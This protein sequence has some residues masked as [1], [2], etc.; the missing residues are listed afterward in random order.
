MVKDILEPTLIEILDTNQIPYNHNKAE[1]NFYFPRWKGL[2]WL[3]SGDKP[4]KLKGI[5]GGLIGID[6]PFIQD[7]NIY[8]IA[9]SRARHPEAKIKGLVLTGTPE[10][11]NWGY[12]LIKKDSDNVAVYRGSTHDNASNL[13]EEYIDH[14]KE[15]YSDKEI[16]AYV[17]GEFVNMTTG[18]VYYPF[19]P[20]QNVIPNY[21][22]VDFRPLEI[23]CDFNV[24]LMA[25]HIGQE[26]NGQD[27]TFDSVEL[28]GQANTELMCQML[29]SKYPNHRGGYIFFVDMAG[30]QR[31]TSATATDIQIIKE[32]FPA[33]PV[34]FNRIANIK[35]RTDALNARLRNAKG[36]VNYFITEKCKRLIRDYERVTWEML[37]NKA[38]AEDLTHASDGESYR[39][40]HKYPL[41]G[42]IQSTQANYL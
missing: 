11:L 25:W 10:K 30:N 14:L 39:F 4:E 35:D 19:T 32:N 38:R 37:Q 15:H 36:E 5:N 16:Q 13:G 2:I 40:Y 8:K 27:F 3:R 7:E 6:E 41:I 18:L 42:K 29:K 33:S 23:S 9:L 34:F 1:H 12:D 24:G 31:R 17:Y 22:P 28:E 21:T 20:S 26:L